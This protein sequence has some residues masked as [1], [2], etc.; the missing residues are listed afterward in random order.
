MIHRMAS[1]RKAKP[2]LANPVHPVYS[3]VVLPPTTSK[4]RSIDSGDQNPRAYRCL[5]DVDARIEHV[6]Q[7]LDVSNDED[8]L[9]I[10]PN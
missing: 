4:D 3:A 2:N 1:I 9:K 5:H 8:A 10:L 7:F 6:F